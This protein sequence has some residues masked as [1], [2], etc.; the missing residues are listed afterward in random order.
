MFSQV[1]NAVFHTLNNLPPTFGGIC[2]QILDHMA[3]KQ[4]SFFLQIALTKTPSKFRKEYVVDAESNSFC[5]DQQ[6]E[7]QDFKAVLTND[8]NKRQLCEVLLQVWSSS[9]AASRLERCTDVII[10]VH[11]IAHRLSCFNKQVIFLV[12]FH[13][14]FNVLHHGIFFN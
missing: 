13:I 12:L 5:R 8:E 7:S 3:A 10:I 4:T 11:G 6:Q 1:G 14:S 9:A 2:L